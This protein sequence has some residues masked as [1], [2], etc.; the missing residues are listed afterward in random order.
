MKNKKNAQNNGTPNTTTSQCLYPDVGIENGYYGI[1]D[2]ENDKFIPKGRAVYVTKIF[3]DIQ[4]GEQKVELQ[5]RCGN[6][7]WKHVFPREVVS[8][9]RAAELSQYGVDVT[10]CSQ[11]CFVKHMSNE[12]DMTSPVPCYSN[13]GWI[14]GV[15]GCPVYM[16]ADCVIPGDLEL[17]KDAVYTEALSAK[18]CGSRDEWYKMYDHYVAGSTPLELAVVLGVSSCLVGYLRNHI[19]INSLFVNLVGKTSTGKTTALNLAVSVA[20]SSAKCKG[21]LKISWNATQNGIIGFL[22]GNM[23][24]PIGIDELSES[25]STNLTNIIFQMTDGSNKL[26]ANADGK[27]RPVYSWHTTVIS[28]SNTSIYEYADRNEAVQTRVVEFVDVTWTSSAEQAEE[29]NRVTSK[30]AGFLIQDFATALLAYTPDQL[31]ERLDQIRKDLPIVGESTGKEVR[32]DHQLSVLMLA[33]QIL[34]EDVHLNLNADQVRNFLLN[35]RDTL[36]RSQIREED[37]AYIYFLDTCHS[38]SRHFEKPDRT[39]TTDLW[40]VERTTSKYGTDCRELCI[41]R[42]RF[43]DVMVK[44][45]FKSHKRLLKVWKER[46]ILSADSDRLTRKVVLGGSAKTM[47]VI[48]MIDPDKIQ[49]VVDETTAIQYSEKMVSSDAPFDLDQVVEVDPNVGAADTDPLEA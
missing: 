3:K 41:F 37:A 36:F 31:V 46:G 11:Y 45:G 29:I 43:E 42:H 38:E 35:Y 6:K 32:I 19:D 23:G 20:G 8:T 12:M 18:C 21:A 44:G 33:A 14:V 39:V 26:R 16:L 28:T 2:S 1:Y 7:W 9:G 34:Q 49:L 4:T 47:Y 13:L 25:A 5:Y 17:L 15:K 10:S 30:H 27:P 40:G 22:N 24:V 48:R